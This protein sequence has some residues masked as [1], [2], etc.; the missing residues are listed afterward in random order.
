MKEIENIIFDL[1]GV[2]LNIDYTRTIEK[3][4]EFCQQDISSH[5][6][7]NAQIEIIDQFEKGEISA[8]DFLMALN[9]RLKQNLTMEQFS[10]AWNSMLLDL[11]TEH[12]NIL[13]ELQKDY[14][15]YLLSNTNQIHYQ[16]F[17]HIAPQD[18]N[19][20]FKHAYYSHLMGMRKPEVEIYQYV[21]QE[22]KLVAHK[23]LFIDDTEKNILAA[24]K[25]GLKAQF[26]KQNQGLEKIYPLLR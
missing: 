12:L 9:Q 24:Q 16:A 11:P 15:L 8:Q 20:Y 3:L 22:Q 4:S 1:G 6:T 23:T 13:K 21:I 26:W 2:I 25:A 7:Q 17:E 10:S 19:Q 18:F 5:Y 14:R